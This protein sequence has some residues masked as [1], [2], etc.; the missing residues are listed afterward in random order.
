MKGSRLSWV[1]CCISV[2]GLFLAGPAAATIIDFDDV[3]PEGGY[4]VFPADLYQSDGALFSREIPI[5][6][7]EEITP[8]FFDTYF[9]GVGSNYNALTLSP[10]ELTPGSGTEI[11]VTFVVP[12]TSTPGITDFVQVDVFNRFLGVMGTLEAYDWEGNLIDS[13]SQVRP[14]DR[15]GLYTISAEGIHSIL[16]VDNQENGVYW[17][18][19]T[20]NTPTEVPEPSTWLLLGASLVGLGL[21]RRR[22]SG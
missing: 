13:V 1:V 5:S 2:L 20:F 12:G 21:A 22:S 3:T 16:L 19:L 4:A 10:N 6:D 9:D 11:G 17:D 14:S 15:H 8:V 18:N 7:V